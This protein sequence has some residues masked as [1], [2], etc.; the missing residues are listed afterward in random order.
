[1]IF[2]VEGRGGE[3]RLPHEFAYIQ[4]A[5]YKA[6]RKNADQYQPVMKRGA[7][8]GRALLRARR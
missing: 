8:G 5:Q 1:V 4:A 7:A 3:V 6:G 2:S